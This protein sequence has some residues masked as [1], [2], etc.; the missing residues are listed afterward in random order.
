M[1]DRAGHACNYSATLY[2]VEFPVEWGKMTMKLACKY[3]EE[4]FE[5][6]YTRDGV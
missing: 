2:G 5:K 3:I 6:S 1:E 4:T